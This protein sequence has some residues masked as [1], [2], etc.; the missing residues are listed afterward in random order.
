MANIVR[1][2]ERLGIEYITS[3]PD[4]V[5]DHINIKCPYCADDPLY[6]L[7]IHLYT[8][9]WA[10]WRNPAHCGNDFIRLV[11]KLACCSYEEA[12]EIYAGSLP[13]DSATK[14]VRGIL[15]EE[16]I[17]PHLFDAE[18]QLAGVIGENS[19]V[20]ITKKVQNGNFFHYLESRGFTKEETQALCC[21]Y[22]IKACIAGPAKGRIVFLIRERGKL[23]G[24]IGRAIAKSNRR[25]LA[26]GKEV[27]D[28][29]IFFDDLTGGKALFVTEGPFDALKLDFYGRLY[30]IH[31]T[32][33]FGVWLSKNQTRLL[34]E[35]RSKYK[36]L[37]VL[38]DDFTTSL[39][40]SQ[41]LSNLNVKAVPMSST[42]K[43]PGDLT[44]DEVFT[45]F[46]GLCLL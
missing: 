40:I 1:I 28:S 33:I 32:C 30:D 46:E 6:H 35:I 22:G 16:V 3:G 4:V 18:K 31:S 42:D 36:H 45:L 13:I 7:G 38:M 10:C 20:Q 19:L 37:F 14:T 44:K 21:L 34:R 41:K 5:K 25:Y 17:K 24:W 2:L 15:N 26:S 8:N 39:K 11:Q 29:L 43:D 12:E 27:K 23:V 9:K